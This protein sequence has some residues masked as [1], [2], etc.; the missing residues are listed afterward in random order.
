MVKKKELSTDEKLKIQ[1]WTEAGAK[2]A[3]IAAR[4][5]HGESTIR[6]LRAELKELPPGASPPPRCPVSG[7]PRA[8]TH[9]EDKRLKQYIEKFLSKTAK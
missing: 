2:T 9:A 6:S 7:C 8:T 5:G 4:L 3:E 1:V